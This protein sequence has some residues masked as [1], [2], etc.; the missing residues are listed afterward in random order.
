MIKIYLRIVTILLIGLAFSL[1]QF[2]CSMSVNNQS[3][4]L[5]ATAIINGKYDGGFL[6]GEPCGPP[7]YYGIIPGITTKDDA[8][9]KL[10]SN[11]LYQDCEEFDNTIQ[12]GIRGV[13]CNIQGISFQNDADIVNGIGFQPFRQITVSEVIDKYGEPNAVSV[14]P[15][16][17]TDRLPIT[18]GMTLFYD[19][20]KV[21]LGLTEQ[22]SNDIEFNLTPDVLIEGI[23]YDDRDSYILSTRYVREWKGYGI[24]K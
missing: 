3:E 11:G 23:E 7:C 15:I 5:T 16:G 19:S 8:I 20:I 21:G 14:G 13:S 22:K 2:S 4:N 18:T 1:L 17:L 10:R 12:G 24:Y 6:S 9:K